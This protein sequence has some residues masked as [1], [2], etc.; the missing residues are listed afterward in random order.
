LQLTQ[1][2][3]MPLFVQSG[4]SNGVQLAD[5]VGYN[6]YRT[7]RENQL[8]YPY[9]IK[10]MPYIWSSKQSSG[11]KLDGLKVFPNESPLIGL[12]EAA[13]IK[14]TRDQIASGRDL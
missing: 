10:I 3:E 4:L 14:I 9:F 8:E 11:Q 5:L 7:F 2:V 13:G 12:A 6:I 1:L